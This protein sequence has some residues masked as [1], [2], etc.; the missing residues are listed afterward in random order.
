[1]I[2]TA[3]A[4]F[5][6]PEPHN[7]KR[8][9]MRQAWLE[10]HNLSDLSLNAEINHGRW[11]VECPSC[12]NAEFLFGDKRFVCSECWNDWVDGDAIKVAV[13]G[14]RKRIEDL[15][16]TRTVE[17]RNWKYPETVA[18]LIR[19]NTSHGIGV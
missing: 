14:S 2:T 13:P 1:M 8:K 7:I 19:E 10:S 6:K 16:A 12:H 15:L 11:V 18:G 5:A 17:N 3:D 4:Y 9:A